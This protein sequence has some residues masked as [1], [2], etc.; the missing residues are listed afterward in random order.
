MSEGRLSREDMIAAMAKIKADTGY[1]GH[2]LPV[3][4]PELYEGINHLLGRPAGTRV[5]YEDYAR[6]QQIVVDRMTP[7]ERETAFGEVMRRWQG[8]FAQ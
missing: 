5:T 4:S 6:A 3:I 8:G 1:R 7:E 2:S